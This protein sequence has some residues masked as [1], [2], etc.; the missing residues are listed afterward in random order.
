MRYTIS[1]YLGVTPNIPDE[2]FQG[3]K[4]IL[5]AAAQALASTSMR[6][7][8]DVYRIHCHNPALFRQQV[9]QH[10]P[11]FIFYMQV[12]MVT[13]C[14]QVHMQV[15]RLSLS[16]TTYVPTESIH[17]LQI[18][19]YISRTQMKRDTD[20]LAYNLAWPGCVRGD[21]RLYYFCPLPQRSTCKRV[22]I[23][24]H[25]MWSQQNG[26]R[27]KVS[28]LSSCDEMAYR[29]DVVMYLST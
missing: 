1:L 2:T 25:R 14:R 4:S 13:L 16:S 8:Q 20:S 11:G 10:Q 12:C 28:T 15:S 24:D 18:T 5:T 21:S 7:M 26:Q 29:T 19:R 6:Y 23:I 17:Q 22:K 9:G 27:V 3:G